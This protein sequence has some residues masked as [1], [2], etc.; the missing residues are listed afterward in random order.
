[1]PA[2]QE[3]SL[4]SAKM[5]LSSTVHSIFRA[6]LIYK[7]QRQSNMQHPRSPT[8]FCHQKGLSCTKPTRT[9]YSL[10]SASMLTCRLAWYP[11]PWDWHPG[12]ILG[13]Q[14]DVQHHGI[15]NRSRANSIKRAQLISVNTGLDCEQCCILYIK[16]RS[17]LYAVDLVFSLV[18]SLGLSCSMLGVRPDVV[19]HST[20]LYEAYQESSLTSVTQECPVCNGQDV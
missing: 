3:P 9:V 13:V 1:M 7:K 18:D 12:S 8:Q 20:A 14:P 19:H 6:S 10:M 16:V 15:A 4:K 17:V 11:P 5:G 2:Y